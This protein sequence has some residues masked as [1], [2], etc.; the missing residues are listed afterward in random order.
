MNQQKL[1][2]LVLYDLPEK[3]TDHRNPFYLLNNIERPT[4]R[5]VCRAIKKL[6]WSLSICGVFDDLEEITSTIEDLKPDCVFNLCETFRGQRVHESHIAG[7]LQMHGI[8]FTGCKADALQLAKDKALTKMIAKYIGVKVPRFEIVRRNEK[9]DFREVGYPAIVKP[10]DREG[11][12]GI[13]IASVVYDEAGAAERIS[14]VH[15]RLKSD[16]IIEQYIPGRELYVGVMQKQDEIISFPPREL[17]MDGL[18][19][20]QPM[21]ATFKAKWDEQYRK[22]HQV[23]TGTAKNLMVHQI[24]DLDRNSKRL[25]ETFKMSGYARVDWRLSL[26]GE[27]YLIEVNPNPAL[28]MDDDF[29]KAGKSIG[30][31]Y[32]DLIRVIVLESLPRGTS[33]QRSNSAPQKSNKNLFSDQYLNATE[34]IHQTNSKNSRAS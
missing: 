24:E 28:S 27:A 29:A 21:I 1:H 25:F 32:N 30:L 15:D 34:S 6:G 18:K 20:N 7:L 31:Q 4:E 13:A 2:V 3:W 16:V 22:R 19:E 33:D 8:P 12:E 14:F 26:E 5:D 10:L 11:S 9:I 23:S 17:F